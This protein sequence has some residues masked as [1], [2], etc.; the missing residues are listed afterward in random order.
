M[1]DIHKIEQ[2]IERQGSS[3]TRIYLVRHAE[4]EGNVMRIFQGHIDADIS[5]RGALQLQ[6]LSERFA[7]TA[8]DAVVASP[9]RRAYKTAEALNSRHGLYIRTDNALMEINGGCFEGQ[10]W[11]RLPALYPALHDAWENRPWDFEPKNGESMRHV[12]AR[13][14]DALAALAK[15][16]AG[17]A[18][19]V[20]SH[21]CAIRNYLCFAHGWPIERLG[22]VPWCDNTAVSVIDYDDGG[23]P[24]IIEEND[25]SHLDESVSTF[26]TQ[27][28]WHPTGKE[29]ADV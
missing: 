17:G 22:D 29:T 26:A 1:E 2:D 19:C 3:M 23:K 12:Y 18:V 28:W 20:V 21:G 27:D 7:R 24:H 10:P 4:A 11:E 6:R 25:A 5:P 14:R 15:A 8:F 9:L 16:H 13:M